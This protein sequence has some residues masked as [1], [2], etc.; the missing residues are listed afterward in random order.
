MADHIP[1][2]GFIKR[3]IPTPL[4][5]TAMQILVGGFI[6][7]V[8]LTSGDWMVVNEASFEGTMFLNPTASQL[9]GHAGPIYGDAILCDPKEIA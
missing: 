6:K 4:T 1:A 9:A 5:L 3:N 7:F 2:N 8:E